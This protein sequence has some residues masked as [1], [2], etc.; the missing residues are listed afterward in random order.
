MSTV[1]ALISLTHSFYP[2]RMTDAQI[3]AYMNMAQ[4]EISPY[5]GLVKE[6]VSLYTV[7][8]DDRVSIPAAVKDI[9]NIITF[10][11]TNEAEDIDGIVEATEMANSTPYTIVSQ[12]S[13]ASRLSLTHISSGDSDT[14][15]IITVMGTVNGADGMEIIT[16]IADTK[17][18]G[19]VYFTAITSITGYSWTAD[20]DSDIIMIGLVPE[21]YDF[22]RYYPGNID[23][24]RYSGNI[25]YQEYTS[26]GVKSLVMHPTP[27]TTDCNIRIRYRASLSTLSSSSQSDSPDFDSEYHDMLSMYAAAM[28]AGSGASPDMTQYDHHM[29]MYNEKMLD[30]WKRS[31]EK[32]KISLKKRRDNKIWHS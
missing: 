25:I 26:A 24:T 14:L 11:V 7:A 4:N 32:D 21:R 20:G 27:K 28:V 5:F 2:S 9:A 31:L 12:P 29:R 1:E 18:C 6:D 16:P 13:S 30:L 22:T 3:V 17:V 10:D 15:G 23:E 19:S 8:D